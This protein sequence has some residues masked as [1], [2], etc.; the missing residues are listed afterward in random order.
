MSAQSLPVRALQ[1][2]APR[3]TVKEGV[4]VTGGPGEESAAREGERERE[5]EGQRERAKDH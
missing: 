5:G 1:R 2:E 4:G 3:G